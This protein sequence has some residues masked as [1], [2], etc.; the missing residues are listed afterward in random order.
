VEAWPVP[1]I[2]NGVS[3]ENQAA[4]DERIPHLLA[5]PAG[6][7]FLSME[8]L[9]EET[10]LNM[11]RCDDEHHGHAEW[12]VADDEATPWC[13]E[14]DTERSY[15]HWLHPDGG[16]DWVIAGCESGPRARPCA[17]AWLR[18]IRDQCAEAEVPF[19][20][21]QATEEGSWAGD[22]E[23][24]CTVLAGDNSKHKAGGVVE[25]PYLDGVQHAAF[26]EQ[27]P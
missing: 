10:D 9:L 20:L 15:S 12:G 1:W 19:F 22:A 3:V 11:P 5:T 26:P 7:R 23:Y 24:E 14:C 18:R 8:P 13:I 27:A 16:I 25:L 21:K 2:W 17:P 4:A 6:L